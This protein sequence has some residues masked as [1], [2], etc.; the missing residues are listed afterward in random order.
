MARSAFSVGDNSYNFWLGG[1]AAS[2]NFGTQVLFGSPSI[3]ARMRINSDTFSAASC[4]DHHHRSHYFISAN[5]II[6]AGSARSLTDYAL[7]VG[8]GQSYFRGS[9]GIGTTT[10]TS[11]LYTNDSAAKTANYTS[12]LHNVIDTSSHRVGQQDRHG[13]R[14]HRHLER[15]QRR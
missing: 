1:G 8:S 12:V 11:L 5:L 4:A 6:S 13:Y 7:Y 15:H 3:Y 9:V 2:A 10:P 14:K